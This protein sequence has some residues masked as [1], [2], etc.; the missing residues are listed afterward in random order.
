MSQMLNKILPFIYKWE[1]GFVNHPNDPGG[2]TNRGITQKTYDSYRQGKGL[3]TR[4]VRDMA[5]SEDLEIYTNMY[6]KP[7][8]EDLGFKLA[9]CMMD[10]AVN[11]GP[12]RAQR[13]LKN[14]GG[15]H[16]TYIQL[17]IAK[18]KELIERN[19]KLAVFERG[20]MNRLTDLRRFVELYDS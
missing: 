20:W 4:S 13:F 17:R 3:P 18:Y 11:M 9:A 15:S 14:C 19:P 1:G 7:E 16:V 2:A 6:W 10:T 12:S 5:H 8:W